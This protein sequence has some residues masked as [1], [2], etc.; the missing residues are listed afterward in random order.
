ML[1]KTL[2]L[3][4]GVLKPVATDHTA[5]VATVVATVV[6]VVIVAFG[7]D[8]CGGHFEICYCC[9]CYYW[10]EKVLLVMEL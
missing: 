10:R 6:V 7:E 9:C 3:L 5:V 8:G 1:P 2:L 4:E